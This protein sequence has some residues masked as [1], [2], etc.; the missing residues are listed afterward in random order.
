MYVCTY[1]ATGMQTFFL[2][3]S[4]AAGKADLAAGK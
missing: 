3:D 4:L 2:W 1:N